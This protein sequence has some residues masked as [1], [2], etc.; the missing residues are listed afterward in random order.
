MEGSLASDRSRVGVSKMM[1]FFL[2]LNFMS[3]PKEIFL[4]YQSVSL[5]KSRKIHTQ[6]DFFFF[7]FSQIYL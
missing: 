5:I 4:I 6:V 3:S 1:P 2:N 7:V